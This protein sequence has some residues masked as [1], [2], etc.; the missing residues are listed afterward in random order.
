MSATHPGARPHDVGP[1]PA[2]ARSRWVAVALPTEHGGWGLTAE[3]VLLGLLV[4]PSWAGAALGGAAF[5]AFLVRTPVKVVLVDRFRHRWLPRTRLAAGIAAAELVALLGLA[6]L[7][8]SLAGARWLWPV[9]LAAP[10]VAVELWFDM[11]SRSRRTVP[12]LAGAVGIA[13]AAAAVV[14]ADGGPV[15]LAVGAWLVLAGRATGSIPFVRT[16]IVRLRSGSAPRR[17]SDLA[18]L[19]G[20]VLGIVAAVVE[21]AYALGAGAV[22]ALAVAQVVGVRRPPVPAKVLGLRQMAAGLAVVLAA[23]AGTW[24]S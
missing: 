5:L 15:A 14:L 23:A 1:A 9:A 18:Q 7:A 13:G 10:L 3:P 16:Q 6:L 8:W 2:G 19:A 24:I 12:E 11:R 22:V 20:T 4:A 17:G 21:R